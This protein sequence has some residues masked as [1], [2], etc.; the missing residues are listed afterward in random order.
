MKWTLTT[1][2]AILLA[3]LGEHLVLQCEPRFFFLGGYLT[4]YF[5]SIYL[6]HSET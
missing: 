6:K 4:S 2:A 1:A 5:V 3:L